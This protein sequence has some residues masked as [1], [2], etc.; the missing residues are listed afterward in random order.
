MPDQPTGFG[1]TALVQEHHGRY[2]VADC[3]SQRI[4]HG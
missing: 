3:K 4:V 2:F 1:W